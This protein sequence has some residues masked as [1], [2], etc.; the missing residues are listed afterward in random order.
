MTD[1]TMPQTQLIRQNKIITVPNNIIELYLSSKPSEFRQVFT[2]I[3]K[4]P[5]SNNWLKL[6][7]EYSDRDKDLFNT[8]WCWCDVYP[9]NP[10]N[11]D[12]EWCD[13]NAIASGCLSETI[14]I[15][16]P[17]YKKYVK[18]HLVTTKGP[19]SYLD[20]ISAV[21]EDSESVDSFNLRPT[22]LDLARSWAFWKNATIEQLKD[23]QLLYNRLPQVMSQFKADMEELGFTW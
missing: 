11:N 20:N 21:L 5:N 8:F 6:T 1:E 15:A 2:R 10:A 13:R 4:I 7:L 14:A 22:L 12:Q 17:K 23:T 16:A 9:D 3:F 18:W 19:D